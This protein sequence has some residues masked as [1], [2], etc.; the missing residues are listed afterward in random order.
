MAGPCKVLFCGDE[1]HFAFKYT[2]EALAQDK[3]VQVAYCSR[4]HVH[5]QIAD[6]HVAIPMMKALDADLIAA[7]KKLRLILQFGVGVEG[8]DI[9][10]V[11]W[12]DKP[13]PSACSSCLGDKVPGQL[14]LNSEACQSLTDSSPMD[15]R[16]LDRGCGCPISQVL[17]PAM[18]FLA[19]SMRC[20]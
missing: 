17:A 9:P 11:R 3:D 15:G 7:A 8:V 16:R 6:A 12:A 20:F 4:E 14:F 2:S 5:Q 19:P 18:P 13:A 10:A 1:F